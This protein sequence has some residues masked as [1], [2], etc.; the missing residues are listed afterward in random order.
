M[1]HV[2]PPQYPQTLK[3]LQDQAPSVDWATVGNYRFILSV[4]WSNNLILFKNE[5]SNKIWD[6]PQITFSKKW[7]RNL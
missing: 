4:V 3:V 7:T 5:Y 1:N 2:L 6:T